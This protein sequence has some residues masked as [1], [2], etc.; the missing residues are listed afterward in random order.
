M[1]EENTVIKAKPQ[2]DSLKLQFGVF[3][4]LTTVLALLLYIA[5][6]NILF[7]IVAVL[8]S[9]LLLANA[10]DIAN[11]ATEEYTIDN[12]FILWSGG[13]I[14][15]ESD[16][17]PLREISDI[18]TSQGILQRR[19]GIG[20]VIITLKSSHAEEDDKG[21]LKTVPD[22]IYLKNIKEFQEI[23]DFIAPQMDQ[24]KISMNKDSNFV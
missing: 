2:I 8:G 1:N 19:F 21:N 16:K 13:L 4:I 5:N 6:Y 24:Q 12:Q 14:T 17:T 9:I 7:W 15:S 10:Y 20:T 18:S 3:A 22:K 11:L 23:R